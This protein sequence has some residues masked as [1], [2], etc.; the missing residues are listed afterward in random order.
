MGSRSASS[1]R[2]RPQAGSRLDPGFEHPFA[3]R[4]RPTAAAQAARGLDCPEAPR[5]LRSRA[6]RPPRP[7]AAACLPPRLP[8]PA[9]PLTRAGPVWRPRDRAAREEPGRTIREGREVPR[10]AWG[11]R[12]PPRRDRVEPGAQQPASRTPAAARAHR[13]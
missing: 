3:G 7:P 5:L 9:A 8:R 10:S 6:R 1:Q 2:K 11:L 4:L 13:A 12:H